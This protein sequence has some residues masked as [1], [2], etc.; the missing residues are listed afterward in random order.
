MSDQVT[1]LP[2][3]FSPS[4]DP[5]FFDQYNEYPTI[6]RSKLFILVSMLVPNV[7]VMLVF[8]SIF[9]FS[10][11]AIIKSIPS[12]TSYK[13]SVPISDHQ[14]YPPTPT[15]LAQNN[16]N[17]F[18]QKSNVTKQIWGNGRYT[19]ALDEAQR[20]LSLA[21]TDYQKA[22][23]YYW[24]GL[25]NYSLNNVDIAETNLL[26]AVQLDGEYAA[27]YVTLSAISM[28]KTDYQ[29]ALSYAQKC[30]ALDPNYAWCHNNLGLVY[31]LT[32]KHEEGIR[33][34]KQAVSLDP[35]SFVF[36]N[37]LKRMQD[38]Q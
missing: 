14:S 11:Q 23:A 2:S 7:F 15:Q 37:N 22:I 25:S 21:D 16:I 6:F 27:P 9:G 35:E 19:E 34:L 26:L 18:N 13:Q 36:S 5:T 17:H 12:E 10:T 4:P 24:I 31:D 29:Q 20:L 3:T 33:E 38:S 32:G 30:V 28:G 1:N 8:G